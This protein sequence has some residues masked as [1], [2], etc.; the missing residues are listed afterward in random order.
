[1]IRWLQVSSTSG[2]CRDLQLIRINVKTSTQIDN[3]Y[4]LLCVGVWVM[5][6]ECNLHEAGHDVNGH[7]EDNCAIVL[8]GDPIQGLKIPELQTGK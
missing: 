2:L 6:N 4:V 3:R 8:R 7:G 1:M 5:S